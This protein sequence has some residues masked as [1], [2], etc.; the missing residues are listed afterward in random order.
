MLILVFNSMNSN[1]QKKLQIITETLDI[2]VFR[3]LKQET[4]SKSLSKIQK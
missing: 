1:F 4:Q 2:E 3:F